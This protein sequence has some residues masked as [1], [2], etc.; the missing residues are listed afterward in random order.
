MFRYDWD[1]H[2]SDDSFWTE[3]IGAAEQS[4]WR[5]VVVGAV[6]EAGVLL[7]AVAFFWLLLP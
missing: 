2:S 6:V 7:G 1:C 5:G 4:F 3:P